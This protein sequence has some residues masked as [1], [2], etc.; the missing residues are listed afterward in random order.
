MQKIDEEYKINQ[1][2]I[3]SLELIIGK[4]NVLSSYEERYCYSGDAA[5]TGDKLYL[6]DVVVLPESTEHISKILQFANKNNIS[7]L[8]RG[9]G[10]N[11][12]GGCVP[13]SGGIIIHTSKMNKILN[14]DENNF[15][16]VVQPGV[17]VE[18]L[19]QKVEKLGLFYPPDPSNLRVS[20][21]G[22]SIALSSSGPRYLKYGGTKD[23]VIGLEVVL[24]NGEIM[25][26]G[27]ITAKNVTGYNLTQLFIG[28]EGTLGIITEAII[29]LIPQPEDK[30]IM[31]VFFGSVDKAANAV[32]SILSSK[33]TPSA[34]DL[35][36]DLTIQTIEKFYP[37]GLP[38][39][40]EA[41]LLIELDG[42]DVDFQ[43]EKVINI[44]RKSGAKNIKIS[45][46]KDEREK[47][48]FARRSAFGAVARLK[49][50]VIT[51]DAVVPRD[52]IPQM[53]KT[54]KKLSEKYNITVCIMGHAGDGNIHPN[55]SLD[56]QE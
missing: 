23:Y 31:L 40:A 55:F 30:N 29:R 6:P 41:A 20:T 21:I 52:K 8:A 45:K 2:L 24:A 42:Y 14:I 53:V 18:Q 44:C 4:S 10:T 50:N 36:D 9:A 16:C 54:I 37:T 5:F 38:L 35:M 7:V 51:E 33:I 56:L 39:D 47:I 48:W 11:H 1:L 22:G 15:T 49:P 3:K 12:A 19:Q 28:S 17:V 32:I 46:N 34:L 43:A 27:G 25:R 13:L 26:T